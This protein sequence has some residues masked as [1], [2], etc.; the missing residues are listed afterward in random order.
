MPT[1]TILI[2]LQ[3]SLLKMNTLQKTS[4][5]A[6]AVAA[7]L[8]SG[9]AMATV[10]T[11]APNAV[12]YAAG[13]SAEV[14]PVIAAV[15]RLMTNVDSYTDVAAGTNSSS[16]RVLYGDLKAAQ[17]GLNAGSH[18]LVIYKFNGG[19]YA[20]GAVPQTTGG[21]TLPYPQQTA[22]LA[23]GDSPT[24]L[25][26]GTVCTT[27]NGGNPTYTYTIG[28]LSNNQQPD[29]GITDVEVG[30]FQGAINN[31]NYPTA[32]VTVGGADLLYDLVEGV[33]VTQALYA[34]KTTFSKSEIAGILDGFY[35]DWSQI[36]DDSGSPLPAGGIIFIDRNVG[37]GTKAAGNQYF[38]GFPGLGANYLTPE[39]VTFGYSGAL[40]L[41]Q[42]LQDVSDT[43]S[44]AQ[45]TDL[46]NA[47]AAGLLAITV[48]SEDTPPAINQKVA[49]TNSYDFVKINGEAVDTG[50]TG[51]NINGS[52]GTSYVNAIRGNYDFFYQPNFNFRPSFYNGGTNNAALAKA[53][54]TTFQSN[55]FP[56][57]ASG[58]QFPLAAPGTLA[59][60][61]RNAAVA[62]G[63]TLDSRSG[64]S[65]AILQPV[66][67]A[68][69]T[70][71]VGSDPL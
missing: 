9:A 57:V 54:L 3:W 24:S 38:L 14:N 32:T 17:G 43:S 27:A 19:S 21:G 45:A 42:T 62:K 63:V 7:A 11:V 66:L 61:D 31:P 65:A 68:S 29:W 26:Q 46:E 47:N 33:A 30:L 69:G 2:N 40:V 4:L 35:T 52:V 12:V 53:F 22:I 49:G 20:N 55:T 58:L 8:G 59:D 44:T 56:G 18:V 34:K 1:P 60:S 39:S 10:P 25:G 64:N 13:G 6:S 23:A 5:I 16:Y 70:L 48:L 67:N 71:P 41:S 50:G 37:S 15:C 36:Y 51:D 28:S